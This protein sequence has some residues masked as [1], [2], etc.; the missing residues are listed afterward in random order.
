MTEYSCN[1]LNSELN[2]RLGFNDVEAYY[3]AVAFLNIVQIVKKLNGF[4]STSRTTLYSMKG[5]IFY[6][7]SSK[8]KYFCRFCVSMLDLGMNNLYNAKKLSSLIYLV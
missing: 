3:K 6:Q 7:P 8:F 4:V 2:K 5:S 1:G